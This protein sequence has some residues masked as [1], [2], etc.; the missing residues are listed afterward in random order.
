V[1]GCK[2]TSASQTV[3][4]KSILLYP[5]EAP[6]DDDFFNNKNKYWLFDPNDNTPRH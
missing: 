3:E 2:K 6:N 5:I 1:L 4:C